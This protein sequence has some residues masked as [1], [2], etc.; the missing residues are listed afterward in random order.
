MWPQNHV[1]ETLRCNAD[2]RADDAM[3]QPMVT[4][5]P[6]KSRKTYCTKIPND[7]KQSLKATTNKSLKTTREVEASL[8]CPPGRAST[9]NTS[10]EDNTS[11]PERAKGSVPSKPGETYFTL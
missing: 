11:N 8:A 5:Y 1:T 7:E 10:S 4:S 6:P 3:S 9:S 2:S